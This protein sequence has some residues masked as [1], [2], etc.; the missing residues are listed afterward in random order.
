MW[1]LALSALAAV[2]SGCANVNYQDTKP[3]TFRGE[4]A[5]VWLGGTDR[6]GDGRFVYVPT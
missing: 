4:V 2:A 5:V 1:R 3:G 6:T